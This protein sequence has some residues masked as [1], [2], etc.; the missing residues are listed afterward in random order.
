MLLRPPNVVGVNAVGVDAVR[1]RARRR[2]ALCVLA[3]AQLMLLLDTTVVNVALA[4][5]Q[6]DLGFSH[7][8]LAW[9]VNG[10]ALPFGGLLLLGG[11]IA[12]LCGRR[13]IFS[14]GLALFALASALGGL[15]TDP[16]MLVTSRVLQGVGGALVAPAA[17]SLV[18]VLFTEPGERAAALS[19]WGVLRGL[20][21]VLGAVL[22]GVF[23]AY[24]SWRWVFFINLP[25]AASAFFLAPRLI[26]E[27]RGARAGR[28][29]VLGAVLATV[30]ITLVV[31]GLLAKSGRAWVSPQVTGPG[32]V[33]LILFGAFILVESR[34]QSP[35][36]P[37]RFF[38]SRRRSIGNLVLLCYSAA[39]AVLFFSMAL[40]LQQV[41]RLGPLAA[42]L[43]FVPIGPM[44]ML[45]GGLTSRL[46]P[47][48]GMRWVMT[49]G[50]ALLTAAFAIF[51][52]VGRHDSSLIGV[53]AG[54]ILFPLGAGFVVI[55]ATIASV[56]GT[57]GEDAGIAGGINNASQQV[58][59][60][61]GLAA[62]VSVGDGRTAELL[63]HGVGTAQAAAS[64]YGLTF[65]TTGALM[66]ATA[67]VVLLGITRR[68]GP[69]ASLP[70]PP[71]ADEAIPS[72]S[73]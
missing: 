24:I 42:G 37:L 64:G 46:L 47:R 35:L 27:S 13:R 7:V 20:G 55:S 57:T 11:R 5:I 16:A 8:G 58:G 72:Q 22:S 50:L 26:P 54:M 51:S 38:R 61:I 33:G 59:L 43:S 45:S 17:L 2:W 67:A 39:M 71:H 14:A 41:L 15:A 3:V 44:F 62:L 65:A 28:P 1:A 66:A 29:D 68:R 36:V 48:L 31:Y 4:P 49:G 63:R 32:M 10:Y 73:R 9:V 53:L 6:R 25:I 23:V 52:G 18:T 34:A 21:A 60:A 69:T 40:Y 56:D 70:A 19:L 12:D 30:S